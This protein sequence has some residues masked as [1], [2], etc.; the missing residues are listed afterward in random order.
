MKQLA[1][2][3]TFF[4]MIATACTVTPAPSTTQ[5]A[6]RPNTPATPAARV[7]ATPAQPSKD[8][9]KIAVAA[10]LSSEQGTLGEGFKLS[11]Q[12][13]VKQLA[14]P[15]ADLGFQVQ[16]V[17][18]DD[19]ARPEMATNRAKEIAADPDVLV[20]IG[21]MNS[22]A[23]LAASNVY[24]DADLAMVLPSATKPQLT[25]RG[26]AN[27]NRLFSR[28]DMQG[29]A[30]AHFILEQLQLKKIYIVHDKTTDYSQ[31]TAQAFMDEAKKIGAIISGFEGTDE[32]TNFTTTIDAMKSSGTDAVFFTGA[33]VQGANLLRQMREKGVRAAFIATERVDNPEFPR[34]AGQSVEG[35]YFETAIPFPSALPD[36][37]QFVK[38]YKSE[39]GKDA[40]PF[41]AQAYDATAIALS[42]MTTL[43][44]DGKPT[45]MAL[46]QAIRATQNYKGITG[47]YSFNSNGDPTLAKYFFVKVTTADPRRWEDNPIFKFVELPP[48]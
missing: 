24:K 1:L 22:D 15:L 31:P 41:G 16:V 7:T 46:G 48:P 37:A 10:P 45:R 3:L 21:N 26:Y 29:P 42:A 13:A 44:K 14:K 32:K 39:F 23:A 25:M 35:M 12:L 38:D 28:D 27:V 30:A 8:G 47:T 33:Y 20:V 2:F 34:I 19:Q 40:P 11:A 18:F 43:A 9:I 17:V 5:T 6:A 36:A 4:A